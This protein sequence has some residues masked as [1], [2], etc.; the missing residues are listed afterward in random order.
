MEL[1]HL[2]TPICKAPPSSEEPRGREG[3]V[4]ERRREDQM[5]EKGSSGVGG[6][7]PFGNRIFSIISGSQEGKWES[8]VSFQ[9]GGNPAA[10]EN[11]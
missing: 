7:F 8:R 2:T 9:V 10:G 11:A 4:G 3:A 1:R 6:E 5:G